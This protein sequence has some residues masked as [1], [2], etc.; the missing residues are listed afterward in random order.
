[1]CVPPSLVR[2]LFGTHTRAGDLTVLVDHLL[3]V[4]KSSAL[5][6]KEVSIVI[7][8]VLLGAAD[9]NGKDLPAVVKAVVMEIISPAY[10][11]QQGTCVCVCVCVCI[12]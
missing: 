1:M 4:F 10:W 7:G 8:H 9:G 12:L 11:Q 6:R 2:N 5:Y 3:D